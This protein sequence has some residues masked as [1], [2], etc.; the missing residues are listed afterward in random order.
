LQLILKLFIQVNNMEEIIHLEIAEQI[1]YGFLPILAAAAPGLIK[2]IGSLFGRKKKK[3]AAVKAEKAKEASLAKVNNFKFK[4]AFEGIQGAAYDPV[5]NKAGQIGAAQT[6]QMPSLTA[7]SGYSAQGY[8]A[9]GYDA[10]GYTAQGYTAQGTS[11]GPLLTGAGTGL[12]NEFAN[13]QVSTAGAELAAQEADQALAASQDLAAQAGTGAGGATALAA[14]AA[15]SKAQISSDIDRQVKAN[16]MRRAE[17]EMKLQRDQLAQSNL[18]SQ[19]ALGQEQFNA[20][21]ANQ[22][23]QFSTAAT[24]QAAQFSS[25]AANQAAQ[26]GANAQNQAAQFGAQVANDAAR[27]GAQAAN[28]F[29]LSKFN[30]E[31]QMNQ[32]NAGAQNQFT[33][34]QFQAEEAANRANM[35]AANQAAQFGAQMGMEAQRLQAQGA[36][37][38]Q[39]AQYNRLGS[40]LSLQAQEAGVK[41]AA[42]ERQRNMLLGGLSSAAG[43]AVSAI[44]FSKNPG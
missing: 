24:N 32:F 37:D 18:S 13:L 19:F 14:A 42:N 26:F 9:Q 17:G 31:A 20:A 7:P 2:G 25:A 23:A 27:F 21:Q 39:A 4:N 44:D 33:M 43:A 30:Q 10:Q 11:I 29:A 12:T 6:A 38:I 22:A 41:Q 8:D 1:T 40:N 35:Q 34:Q 16:E 3:E 28:Q 36:A 5:A 15:K